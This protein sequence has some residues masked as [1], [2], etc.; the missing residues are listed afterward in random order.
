MLELLDLSSN[1]LGKIVSLGVSFFIQITN[2]SP[3]VVRIAAMIR[4]TKKLG[5]KV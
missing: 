5:Y 2:P 3:L 1:P 4:L